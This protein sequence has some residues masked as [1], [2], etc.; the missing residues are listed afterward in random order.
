MLVKWLG[1]SSFVLKFD[2][3]T[4]VTDPYDGYV[5]Y[6]M[7]EVFADVVTVSHHH[8]DH[9]NVKAVSGSPVVLDK[10][11][12]FESAGVKISGLETFHDKEHGK[13]RGKTTVFKF[14]GD[15]VTVCHMGD[16][17]EVSADVV[18]FVKGADVLL[19]PVGGNYTIDSFDALSYVLAAKPAFAVPMHYKTVDCLFDIDKIDSFIEL[20]DTDH[21][22]F[23]DTDNF[24]ADKNLLTA[25]PDTQ[26]I[27]LKK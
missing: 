26:I 13:R 18:E 14:V 24:E 22:H 19:L 23:L 21:V 12:C 15:G 5:G 8:A 16:V 20:F 7:P 11:D 4:V 6:D 10:A 3:L 2:N 9:D 25:Y 1:H 27:V 17:G